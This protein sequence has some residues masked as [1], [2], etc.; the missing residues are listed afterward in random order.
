MSAGLRSPSTPSSDRSTL[1]RFVTD[2]VATRL[3]EAIETDETGRAEGPATQATA[4]T[5]DS[6]RQQILV[7]AWLSDELA[8]V[9]QDRMHRG[10]P[11]LS[12]MADREIRSRVVAELTGTG[13]LERFMG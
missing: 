12:E 6:R 8:T 13:P 10:E 2:R 5:A 7:G 11:P 4:L 3:V 9:N 1:V